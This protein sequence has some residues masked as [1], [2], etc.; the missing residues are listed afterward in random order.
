MPPIHGLS[1]RERLVRGGK[2]RLGEKR[3]SPKT[4]GEYPAAVDYFIFDPADRSL[5]EPFKAIYGEKPRS[6][7]IYFPS[8]DPAVFFPQWLKCYGRSKGLFCKGDG[9]TATRVQVDDNGK[10]VYDKD[11]FP[12]LHEIEC[13][14]EECEYYQRKQCRPIGSLLFLLRDFGGL[15]VW[16]IDTSSWNSIVNINSKVRQIRTL[17]GGRIAF[18][19]LTL[20]LVPHQANVGGSRKVV[21]VLD[22]NADFPIEKA[23]QGRMQ[24]ML[25]LPE[26]PPEIPE[27]S[28]A[29][30]DDLYPATAFDERSDQ[31]TPAT[32]AQIEDAR[33]AGQGEK[34][35]LMREIEEGARILGWSTDQLQEAIERHKGVLDEVLAEI[36]RLVDERQTGQGSQQQS[37]RR[38]TK[39]SAASQPDEQQG[40]IEIF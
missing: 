5:L 9:K 31:P 36:H 3:V 27:A 7:R 32:P 16:Q 21:Y 34:D 38:A 14:H 33:R 12:V 26:P 39:S 23:V 4:G 10:A 17:T 2:F 30:P 8:D 24:E 13:P 28:D 20:V 6:L 29:L 22:L 18:L 19:P 37:S 35:D 15:R 11:G 40:T 25:A 1:D